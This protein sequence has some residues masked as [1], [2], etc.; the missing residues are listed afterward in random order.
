[1]PNFLGQIQAISPYSGQLVPLLLSVGSCGVALVE[2]VEVVLAAS[3]IPLVIRHALNTKQIHIRA[4]QV[5]V[6]R[7]VVYS[8]GLQ[9]QMQHM[10]MSM[11]CRFF[12]LSFLFVFF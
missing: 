6:F 5:E 12:L 10:R 8:I 3:D 7:M 4:I 9:Q 2:K 11:A 1:L